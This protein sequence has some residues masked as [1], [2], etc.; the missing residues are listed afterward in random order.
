MSRRNGF[1]LIELLVVIAIIG[2]LIALLLPAVQSAREA[3]RS[4]SCTNNLKQIGLA[5]LN[6]E[7]A[8]DEFPAGAM[9]WNSAGTT[10]VGHT[11]FFMILPYLEQGSTY[12]N[13]DLETRA[14]DPPNATV[15]NTQIAPYHCPSDNAAGRTLGDWFSRSNYVLNYGPTFK[16]PPGAVM[17]Q[18]GSPS[19]P[20]SDLE[21][22][23][24][25]RDEIART[26]REF[27]DGTSKTAMVSEVRAGQVDEL[28]YP[29][30]VRG[31]WGF[32]FGGSYYTHFATPNSSVPDETRQEWCDPNSGAFEQ[33]APCVVMPPHNGDPDVVM[34]FVARSRHPGGVKVLFA[35]GHVRFVSDSISLDTWQAM[36]TIDGKEVLDI[37]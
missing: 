23:G 31:T 5:L 26:L 1:T 35:D 12:R 20:R 37:D 7:N 32:N 22:G 18:A 3:A 8:H 36:S 10:W 28:P 25:F 6:H 27:K 24:A 33:V 13:V 19:R 15:L 17:P 16:Y 9:G 14:M 34:R 2:V 4:M 21:N 30:D 29:A 11:A